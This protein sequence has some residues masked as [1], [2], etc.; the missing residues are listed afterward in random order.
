MV[1]VNVVITETS[2]LPH[3]ESKVRIFYFNMNRCVCTGKSL[4]KAE[5]MGRDKY[6]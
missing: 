5:G 6:S 3:F 1:K 2:G 4:C